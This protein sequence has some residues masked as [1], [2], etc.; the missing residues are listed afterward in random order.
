MIVL[1]ITGLFVLASAKINIDK[2]Y[3]KMKLDYKHGAG[4]QE[5]VRNFK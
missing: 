3:Y 4:Y 1:S 5:K 2:S